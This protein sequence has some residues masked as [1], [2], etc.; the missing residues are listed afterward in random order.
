MS[1]QIDTATLA[2]PQIQWPPEPRT[3]WER[4][5]RAFQ[6]LLPNL[7]Q[8]DRGRYVAVHNERMFDSDTNE[9]ALITRMLAKVGN[10]DIHVGLVTDQPEPV[11]RSGVVRNLASKVAP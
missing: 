11:Y 4:E 1:S 9:M 7:L 2:A 3:K 8:A 6:R 10:V 5:Y